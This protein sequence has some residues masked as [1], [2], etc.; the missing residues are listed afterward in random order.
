MEKEKRLAREQKRK[1]KLTGRFIIKGVVGILSD[2][3]A[4]TEDWVSES[5]I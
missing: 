5:C 2:T 3:F 1:S 4:P